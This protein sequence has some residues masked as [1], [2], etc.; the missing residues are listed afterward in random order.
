M[1]NYGTY[2]IAFNPRRPIMII[3]C[4]G[5]PEKNGKQKSRVW[6]PIESTLSSN[7]PSLA[8]WIRTV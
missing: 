6:R 2:T 8:S 3:N 4:A 1:N 7:P 5:F